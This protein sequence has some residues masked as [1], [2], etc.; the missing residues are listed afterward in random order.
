M[1]KYC[2]VCGHAL[3]HDRK[4]A[5]CGAGAGGTGVHPIA[6]DTQAIENAQ[7]VRLGPVVD[8]PPA[9]VVNRLGGS[10]IEFAAYGLIAFVLLIVSLPTGGAADF[11]ITPFLLLMVA[12]RDTN[13]GALSL[14]KRIGMMRVVK[15]PSGLPI[16][17]Y[18]AL[19]R[20]VYYLVVVATFAVPFFN[21]LPMTLLLLLIATDVLLVF[22]GEKRL[23]IGDW[24]A[25][26]QVVEIEED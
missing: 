1:R 3:G 20:N 7:A 23:R 2:T 25:G 11:L 13:C 16:S 10:G 9:G 24:L 21:A 17:N 8:L 12:V 14:A 6:G 4:C 22:F 26:T 5:E 15:R 19:L 18:E